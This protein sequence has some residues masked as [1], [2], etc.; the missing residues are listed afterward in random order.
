M[1][2]QSAILEGTRLLNN[3]CISTAKLDSEIIMMK[4]IGKDKKYII[5]NN[6]EDLGLEKLN[7][8]KKLIKER[9]HRKPIAYLLGKKSF[10]KYEFLVS[11]DTLIPRPDTELIIETILKI[12]KIRNKI[13]VLDIGSNDGTLLKQF[14]EK[15]HNVQ[16]FD[17]A[18]TVAKVA[19]A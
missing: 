8:F 18:S 2:I 5:L 15:G 9:S 1:N 19:I 13:S 12:T 4:V 3:K 7:N 17:P 10:W 16:G 14:K 6:Y 11:E